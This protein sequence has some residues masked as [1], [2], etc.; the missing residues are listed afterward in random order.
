[1]AKNT[2]FGLTNLCA[3]STALRN[4]GAGPAKIETVQYPMDNLEINDRYT[5]WRYGAGTAQ[6]DV[7]FDLLADVTLDL[8]GVHGFRVAAG[9]TA[10]STV[11]IYTATAAA[12]LSSPTTQT[13]GLAL[14]RD[15]GYAPT[16]PVTARYVRFRFPTTASGFSV[17]NFFAGAMTDTGR[18][19]SPQASQEIDLNRRDVTTVGGG[20]LVNYVGDEGGTFVLPFNKITTTV[21]DMLLLIAR[22]QNPVTYFDPFDRVFQVLVVDGRFKIDHDWSPTDLWSGTL[23]LMRLP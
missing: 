8:F 20:L 22:N 23:T 16:S 4:G 18:L 9:E 7:E 6:Y 19:Y 3:V 2:R 10:P 15:C 13:T 12:T 11:S 17:G 21:K 1:M 5:P 14:A